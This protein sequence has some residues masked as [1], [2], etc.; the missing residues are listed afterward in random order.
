MVVP[1]CLA[2][3]LAVSWATC[4]YHLVDGIELHHKEQYTED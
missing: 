4:P 1:A 3:A 2:L